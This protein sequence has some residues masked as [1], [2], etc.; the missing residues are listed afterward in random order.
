MSA[1]N[2]GAIDSRLKTIKQKGPINSY[3]KAQNQLQRAQER[4]DNKDL[5]KTLGKGKKRLTEKEREKAFEEAQR[6]QAIENF[7]YEV[8]RIIKQKIE[9]SAQ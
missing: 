2:S 9:E 3:E 4:E 6:N 1:K 7:A 5:E 8:E